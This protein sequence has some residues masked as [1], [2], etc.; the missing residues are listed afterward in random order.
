MG[1]SAS[2][3]AGP[4]PPATR[5]PTEAATGGAG[6]TMFP[7]SP[8]LEGLRSP[9]GRTWSEIRRSQSPRWHLVWLDLAARYL[10]LA[11]GYA[12]ACTVAA[13][14]GNVVGLVLAPLS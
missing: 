10:M 1:S 8:A 7:G 4:I 14:F 3:I 5:G 9:D 11:L 13:A 6:K 2:A 12:L